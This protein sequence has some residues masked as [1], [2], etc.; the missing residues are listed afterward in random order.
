MSRKLNKHD[1]N[2]RVH[3][4]KLLALVESTTKWRHYLHGLQVIVYTD[5]YVLKYLQ[6][7]AKPLTPP[8]QV[9]TQTPRIRPLHSSHP[10]KD[11]H[12]G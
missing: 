5:S 3:E 11:Q 8:D 1:V 7:M 2:Y 10:G 9:V 12:C 6:T 4:K